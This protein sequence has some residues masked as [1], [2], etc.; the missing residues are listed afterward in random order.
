MPAST[1]SPPATSPPPRHALLGHCLRSYWLSHALCGLIAL[2]ACIPIIW[3]LLPERELH[4]MGAL[5][6]GSILISLLWLMSS[7]IIEA[8]HLR[9]AEL[10][11]RLL[12]WL[13][14]WGICIGLLSV[15][16]YLAQP[17]TPDLSRA[18]ANAEELP[19]HLPQEKLMGISSLQLYYDESEAQGRLIAPSPYLTE[20]SMEHPQILDSY[21]KQS[22]RWRQH[23]DD[24][25][26][27]KL[28]HVVLTDSDDTS[29]ET[30]SVHASIRRL[31]DG[32]SLPEGYLSAESGKPF[33]TDSIF[34]TFITGEVAD[35]ALDLGGGHTLLL[36]WRGQPDTLNAHRALNA[37]IQSIDAQFEDLATAPSEETIQQLLYPSTSIR[38]TDI[39]FRL[40]SPPSQYGCYQA[41]VYANSRQNGYYSLIAREV[42]KD[43]Q[44]ISISFRSQ[45]SY[46]EQEVF[47]HE[48]PYSLH[49]WMLQ[50]EWTPGGSGILH[51][52]P[53][54]TFEQSDT[55]R[56]IVIDLELWFAP[57]G[58]QAPEQLLARKR[59]RV[60][61]YQA[62][63][64]LAAPPDDLSYAALAEHDSPPR[65]AAKAAA[66][67]AAMEFQRAESAH[68]ELA[69]KA[70]IGQRHLLASASPNAP[71]PSA[72]A[73]HLCPEAEEPAE[74]SPT[75]AAPRAKKKSL[76]PHPTNNSSST[77]TP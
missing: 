42:E 44:L 47:R 36:A 63:R 34:K 65:A 62:P 54:F 57:Y 45:Y 26:Y 1:T 39:E 64:P 70:T 43:K 33:P 8:L 66:K 74:P 15:L 52:L 27:G 24:Q 77:P 60:Q 16:A 21:L 72:A 2:L 13:S 7:L 12:A 22:R 4:R 10:I 41:E 69:E 76:H 67:A 46:D 58:N 68:S 37:A 71:P 17:K 61:S 5:I 32:E 25:L 40:N 14:V 28:G 19:I 11:K 29:G 55:L 30:G 9:N 20:L 73:D 38:D 31:V 6:S 18:H 49:S 53:L 51:S 56:S 3:T 48:I 35:I 75:P 50:K 59:Y 23:G